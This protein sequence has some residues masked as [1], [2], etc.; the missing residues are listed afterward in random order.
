[1][2]KFYVG[3]KGVVR[4]ETRGYILLHRDYKSGD[5]WDTPGGR[6][7]DS[8]KFEDTL[9]RE[10]NEELPGIQDVRVGELLGAFRLQKD[11]DGD[12]S[13]VLLYFKV[14]AKLPEE[15]QLSDEHESFK[16][17]NNLEDLPSEG[18]NPQIAAI[19]KNLLSNRLQ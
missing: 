6:M 10:L 4:D 17:F 14:D 7:D 3:V 13:L 8:E 11:I 5:Y 1:M 16:W 2:K 9:R 18:L 19:M 15:V 12:T